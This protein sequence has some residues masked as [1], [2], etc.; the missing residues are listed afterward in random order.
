MVAISQQT[1]KQR[2]DRR[3]R[4]RKQRAE[5]KWRTDRQQRKD[6]KPGTQQTGRRDELSHLEVHQCPAIWFL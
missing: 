1:R 3:Q 2:I 5:R 6:K 4:D